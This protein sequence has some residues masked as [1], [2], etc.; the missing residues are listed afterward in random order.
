M[1]SVGVDQSVVMSQEK[2]ANEKQRRVSRRNKRDASGGGP[3][4][5]ERPK[6]SRKA[7]VRD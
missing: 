5:S 3:S 1:E 6:R 7:V 2:P 4:S